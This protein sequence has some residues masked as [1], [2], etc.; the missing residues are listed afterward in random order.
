MQAQTQTQT[1]PGF[2]ALRALFFASFF[3][4]GLY[5]ELSRAL[6]SLALTAWLWVLGKRR[7]LSL[8]PAAPCIAAALLFLAYLVT[9]LWAAD[10]GLAAWGVAKMLP[11]PLF[12]LCLLQ[13]T[14]EE[15]RLLLRD[16]PAAGCVMTVL[17]CLLRFVPVLSPFVLVS[18]RLGGFFQ[19]P[20][21]F[22]CFLLL[23]LEI[24][25]FDP[26]VAPRGRL[27]R[28]AV[29][30]LGILQAASRAVFLLALVSLAVCLPCRRDK[31]LLRQTLTGIAAGAAAGAALWL[32]TSR[33]AMRHLLDLS[34]H[35]STLLGRLLYW[36]DALPVILRHPFGCGYLGY[37]FMQGSFQTGVYSTRWV[38][39]DLLQLLLDV[40]WL[41]VAVC[42]AA[43]W[44]SF[45]SRR[46]PLWQKLTL[47]TLLAHAFFDFDLEYTALFLLLLLTLDWDG[48]STPALSLR[49]AALT[50]PAVLTA[51]CLWMGASSALTTLG[52]DAAAAAVYPWNTFS[53]LRLLA[54]DTDPDVFTRRSAR[55]ARQ[56]P[57]SAVAWNACALSA[58]RRGDLAEMLTAKRR[59]I[60]CNRYALSEYTDYLDKLLYAAERF[61]RSGQPENARL[62][63]EE[64]RRVPQYLEDLRAA[65]SPL[66]WRI[67]DTPQLELP[68]SYLTRL[69]ELP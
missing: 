43:L 51:A 17:S 42:L 22:A 1:T 63:A 64:A 15:R 40:G 27:L 38:H 11:L 3:A 19:Y 35:A 56:N 65:A 16:V 46:L 7:T 32:L 57:Y 60:A 34:P 29:L 12:A 21:T 6:F 67:D 53:Q 26:R 20:N 28:T 9:P 52:S 5:S 68:A 8:R 18:G 45:R 10:A 4:A 54:Q 48:A 62:C 50:V 41:P 47:A 58:Q 55:L 61:R 14:A 24:L 33:T 23:G 25:L 69:A 39:N 13:L 2:P 49:R 66:A 31:R 59:A 44:R 30:T 36:Q 37:C